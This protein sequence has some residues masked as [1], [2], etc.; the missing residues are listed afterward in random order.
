MDIASVRALK[1]EVAE[2]VIGPLLE[3]SRGLARFSMSAKS[4]SLDTG[5][6]PGIALGVTRAEGE[7]E[8]RLAVRVQ[9]RPL[10][11][12]LDLRERIIEV[13]RG[14]VD[15]RYIGRVNKQ[16]LPW[17]QTR[18][19]PLRI[20]SSVGHYAI[21]A[22]TLGA[23]ATRRGNGRLA[24]LSNNHVL[25]DEDRASVGD[26]ILQPGS[27]DGGR[28]PDDAVAALAAFVALQ[29]SGNVVDA[30]IAQ[31]DDGIVINRS[32]LDGIGALAGVRD[33]PLKPGDRVAKVGRTT[34]S[35]YGRVTAV[36]LDGVVV[37]YDRGALSFDHQIE[38]EGAGD[39]P[40][41]AGG[42]SGSLIVDA[43]R[44]ACALLFAGGDTGG[45]NGKGL[46][47]ANE[48][49]RVLDGL[50]VDLAL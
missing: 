47:F 42:D 25:A 36:E 12:H 14:E 32:D 23:F 16:Q 38:I 4:L 45:S 18:N 50:Q 27:Y 9:Q 5:I 40:F 37:T 1:A 41:S 17:Q 15:Y 3:Q 46:T 8:Y 35:T 24:V 31:L 43:D 49:Q 7:G 48:L 39:G 21:T 28:R 26:A 34:G 22:G 20:G 30:A 44:H 6:R 13:A 33:E 19:R 10:E 29:P 11:S 2:T